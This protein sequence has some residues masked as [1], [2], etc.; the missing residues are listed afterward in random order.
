MG[1][2]AVFMLSKSATPPAQTTL[3]T[4]SQQ[5]AHTESERV[6]AALE[7]PKYDW[8][9]VQGIARETNLP[10]GTVREILKDL[11]D[12]IFTVQDTNQKPVF[13]T[14]RKYIANQ[15]IFDQTLTILSNRLS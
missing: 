4:A 3:E 12:L 13:T 11:S 9:T 6:L 14:R 10:L 8:R 5:S 2:I 1:L 7:N 15:H